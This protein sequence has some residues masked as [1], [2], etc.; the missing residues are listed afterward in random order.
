[1]IKSILPNTSN[2]RLLIEKIQKGGKVTVFGFSRE[3]KLWLSSEID[4]PVLYIAQD[5]QDA[6][7]VVERVGSDCAILQSYLYPMLTD[8]R[9]V[10]QDNLSKIQALNNGSIKMLVAYPEV[11]TSYYKTDNK[12]YTLQVGSDYQREELISG[13]INCGY[14][15]VAS[16]SNV[17][18]FSVHGESIDIY[19]TDDEILRLSFFDTILEDMTLYSPDTFEKLN[20]LEQYTLLSNMCIPVKNKDFFDNII[21]SVDKNI[22]KSKDTQQQQ[23]LNEIKNMV[24]IDKT[25]SHISHQDYYLP[26]LPTCTIFELLDHKVC[27]IVDEYKVVYDKFQEF[28][29][30]AT[31]NIQDQIANGVYLEEHT[32]MLVC[33]E[34][35]KK[36]LNN[37][38]AVAF[39]NISSNNRLFDTTSIFNIKTLPVSK[40]VDRIDA[41]VTDCVGYVRQ[42]YEVVIY[43][44]SEA[45]VTRLKAK[46]ESARVGVEIVKSLATFSFGHVHLLAKEYPYSFG[47]Q[48]E[49]VIVLGSNA[50]FQTTK[51]SKETNLD[52]FT[53]LP[54]VGDYVVHT[55]Y[56]I[57]RYDGNIM[58]TTDN[59]QKEYLV[60]KYKNED[61]VYLPVENLDRLT[62]FVG[63][64]ESPQLSKLGGGEFLK[65][66][67]KVKAGL[68]ELAFSL[69]ALYKEREEK[70]GI[71]YPRDE[72]TE[73]LLDTNFEYTLTK[74]Q[75]KAI[76]EVYTDMA[77]G[78][79]M[80]RLICGD[81]GYGKTEVAIRA[82]LKTALQ[83]YQVA[84]LCPTTILSEQHYYTC[85]DRLSAFG[86]RIGVLNRFRSTKEQK[87]LLDKV[88]RGEIDVLIGTHRLLSKDV[89]FKKLGLLVLDEEQ[90][91]G[92]ADKE[93][94]KNL[95]KD[96]NVLTLSATPIPRTL[97]MSL[98]GIRDISLIAL[99]PLSRLDCITQVVEYSDDLLARAVSKERSRGG[100]TLI[101]YNHVES[102][103]AFYA[104]VQSLLGSDVKVGMAHG[105]MDEKTLENAI[106]Q[107]YNKE[108]DVLVATTLIENGIDLPSAN[109]LVVLDS[110]ALG[111]SQLYQLK[112]RVGRSDKQAYAY[113]TYSKDKLFTTNAYKRL[114]AIGQYSALGSG[115]K[116]A[117]RDLEIRGAGNVL[118]VEQSGHMGKVGYHMYMTLLNQAV[119]EVQGEIQEKMVDSTV[120]TTL[121]AYLPQEYVAGQIE[122]TSVYTKIAKIASC[123][124]LQKVYDDLSTSYGEVPSV[125]NHLLY[126]ALLK[127]WASRYGFT[128][129]VIRPNTTYLEWN[130]KEEYP[131]ITHLIEKHKDSLTVDVGASFAKLLIEN[132][133]GMLD[134]IIWLTNLLEREYTP[135]TK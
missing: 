48:H 64:K 73:K 105:Q 113:F 81:V 50:L 114:E 122:R 43:G 77:N 91:F 62:K 18:D 102:M 33:M 13:I 108:I 135:L 6:R 14:S 66:K 67:E 57:G 5:E 100:Q 21:T 7:S 55:T 38:N 84:F 123:E 117:L 98:M 51:K 72:E 110:H 26:F 10:Y 15:R 87:D 106:L 71:V 112:G 89:V 54:N 63:T 126:I 76:E 107:L 78:K 118:G 90:K 17:G 65:V 96:I 127:N 25:L 34:N 9:S 46:F 12:E 32:Q 19:A 85:V 93:K 92:V 97:H 68:K 132:S 40:Y 120:V 131:H 125:V 49:K 116:I 61:T 11:L 109:T 121:D 99:P 37:C 95:K 36:A 124:Q 59:G 29:K 44:K 56:G 8:T 103:P 2:T 104:R 47:L 60:L 35:I 31:S 75:E 94:I 130:I 70:K 111:L 134:R 39:G 23:A 4:N 3:E 119:S 22:K 79:I 74:D 24:E 69:V 41:L 27:V 88:S 1:M 28:L 133:D 20:N 45:Y 53:T 42:G 128:K 82:I 115:Y 129:C 86:I 52:V 101:V 30:Q 58:L 83:G 80:D 16:V